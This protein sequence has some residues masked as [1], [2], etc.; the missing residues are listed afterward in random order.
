MYI[1][2]DYFYYTVPILFWGW[3]YTGIE[4]L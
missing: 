3:S 2:L 1:I 4:R